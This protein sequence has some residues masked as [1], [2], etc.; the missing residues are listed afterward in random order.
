M[1]DTV[2]AGSRH[3]QSLMT[4]SFS[5]E[6]TYLLGITFRPLVEYQFYIYIYIYIYMLYICQ[7]DMRESFVILS[8]KLD[9]FKD[10]TSIGCVFRNVYGACVPNK[11]VMR[12]HVTIIII[13]AMTLTLSKHVGVIN[14][15][16]SP[17]DCLG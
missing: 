13:I 7:V 11:P 2:I 14:S 12:S 16:L 1:T 10:M 15:K 5:S 9:K 6:G 3:V 4:S 17:V 8:V